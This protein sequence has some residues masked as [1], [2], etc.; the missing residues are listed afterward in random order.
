MIKL[1]S[2]LISAW[3]AKVSASAICTSAITTPKESA[4]E[5]TKERK[6]ERNSEKFFYRELK[7]IE[8]L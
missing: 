3:K 4:L 2:W 1:R 7:T 8:L 6:Q 5:K